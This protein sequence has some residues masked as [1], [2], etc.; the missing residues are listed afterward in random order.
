VRHRDVLR[1]L[2]MLAVAAPAGLRAV[3]ALAARLAPPHDGGP[4]RAGPESLP[5]LALAAGGVSALTS[6]AASRLSRAVERR[7]DADALRLAGG[8]DAFVGFHRRI[9]LQN[10][11]DLDPPAWLVAL[12]ATHPPTAERIGIARA[13]AAGG[14]SD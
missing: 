2:A 8:A 13:Y 3:A 6:P 7:A 10:V 14:G 1:S 12:M 11:A 9:A 4:R 5:A